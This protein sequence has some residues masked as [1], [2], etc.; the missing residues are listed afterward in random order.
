LRTKKTAA[1]KYAPKKALDLGKELYEWSGTFVA[2]FVAVVLILS[3][4]AGIFTVKQSSMEPTLREGETM[5]VSRLFYKPKSG[6]IVVFSKMG[7]YPGRE[8]EYSDPATGRERPLVKRVIAV[9]GDTVRID[10]SANSIYV[11]E[12][13]L[14][15]DYLPDSLVMRGRGESEYNV[16]PGCVFVLGDNR[17]NSQDSR[18]DWIGEIDTRYILGRLVLRIFPLNKLG[19]VD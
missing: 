6:D 8:S 13:K 15:E 3:F 11:N 4:A 19:I 10:Y 7:N 2:A 17:N 9:G 5:L 12:V 14:D 18:S 16:S 1:D